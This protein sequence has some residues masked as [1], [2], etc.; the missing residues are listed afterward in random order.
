[1]SI[2]EEVSNAEK[3]GE[4]IALCTIVSSTGST[5]R[6]EGSKMIVRKNGKISGTVGGGEVEYFVIQEA[7][8]SL[9]DHKIRKLTYNLVDPEKGDPGICGGTLEVY[10]E[11]IIPKLSV[12]VVGAGHVGKQVVHLAKWLGYRT[13]LTDDRSELCSPDFAPG[14]DEYILC[15][16][17]DIPLRVEIN[18]FSYLV[19]ATKGSNVDTVGLPALLKTEAGYIGV[20]GSRKRWETTRKSLVEKGFTEKD[21]SRINSPIGLE[22]GAETPEEIA[23]S[24]IAEV[25]MFSNRCS[26]K[27]MRIDRKRNVE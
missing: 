24:I 19:L 23:V 1:M 10:V 21:L 5:P 6:H 13:I 25:M 14:A 3:R 17:E 16:I 22:L 26:G 9:S 2:Y 11:P 15:A 27:N 4:M 12:V 20:I 18:N 7:L 8:L